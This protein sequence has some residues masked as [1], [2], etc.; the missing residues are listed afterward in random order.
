M[1]SKTTW[2][3][4]SLMRFE[5]DGGLVPAEHDTEDHSFHP[6]EDSWTERSRAVAKARRWIQRIMSYQR[7]RWSIH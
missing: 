1:M 5:D 3:E 7:T 4:L 2:D 6:E